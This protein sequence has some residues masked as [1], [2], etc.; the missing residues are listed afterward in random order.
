MPLSSK[1]RHAHRDVR[2]NGYR[3]V[4]VHGLGAYPE[5]TWTSGPSS[6]TDSEDA[7]RDRV[8]LLRDLFK[9]DFPN[10]RIMAFAHNSDWLIDAPVKSAQQIGDRLLKELGKHRSKHQVRTAK[11]EENTANRGNNLNL[12]QALCNPKDAARD[13]VDSTCGIVFLGTPHQGSPVSRL[14]TVVARVTGFFGSNTGLLLSLTS[15]RE[16]LS[17]LDVRF[18][19]CMKEKEG[20]RQKTEIVAFCE[21]KPTRV[22]GWLSVGLVGAAVLATTTPTLN[23]NQKFVV[24]KLRTVEGAAFNSHA[25]EHVATCL[26]N[27]RHELLD[28]I[29]Q[30]ADGLMTPEHIY[31]LQGK[32]GTGKSTIARTVARDLAARDRLAASF[33]FK[34]GES[35]RGTAR[36]FFTTIAA[37][38]VQSLPAVAKYVRNAI[39]TDPNIAERALGD[40]F[41]KLILEPV[42][43]PHSVSR[44]M[45]VVIDALDECEGDQDVTAVIKLLLQKDRPVVAPLK[46]FVTSRF[47]PPIRL[48]FQESQ[49][50]FIEFPIHE[51]P[52]PIIERDIATFLRFRF[53]E[54]RRQFGIASSWPD[55]TQFENLLRKSI[56]LFIFAATACRFVEDYRQGGGGPDDRLQKI[57]QYEARG[58]FDQTYLPALT[59]MIHG[60][61]GSARRNSVSEF[62]Q[63]VGSIVTLTNPLAPAPLASLLG[64]SAE[65]VNNRLQ[66]LHSVLDVPSDTTSP[67]RIFHESFRDFL[68]RPDP[69]DVHEFWVDEK[70]THEMLAD[71][72]FRLLSEGGYLKKDICGLGAPGKPRTIVDQQTIDRCLPPEARYACLYW[73]HHLKGSGVTLHDEHQALQFL[74]SHFLHWLE[75]LSLMGR[76]SESI[77]LI[78]ELQDLI[79]GYH[80]SAVSDFLHDAKR[81]ILKNRQI[82]DDTPLQL[83]FSG[84]IFAPRTAIIR[85]EFQTELLT[86]ACQLPQ[87]EES[88]SAELQTL[89][90]HSRWV[91]S[92]A[93]SPD[94]RMLASS[95]NDNTV[96]LWDATTGALQ[97]ILEGHSSSVN[98]VY[99]SP[100]GRMI[101]SISDDKIV[102]H[103]DATTGALQQTLEGHSDLVD[104][105]AFSPDGRMVAS[106]SFDQ[107]VRLWDATTGALQQTLE[108]HSAGVWH[109]GG[110][111][112]K[113]DSQTALG[114]GVRKGQ[115]PQSGL[116][117]ARSPELS[118][119][120]SPDGRMLASSF[121]DNIVRLWDATTGA[122]QQALEGHSS[123][124]TSVA[125][126]CDGRMLASGSDD[127]TVRLWHATTGALQQTLEGHS[128]SVVSVTFSSD[129]RMLASGSFDQTVRLWDTATGA[130]RQILEGHSS[131]V[132]SVSFSPDGRMLASGSFDQTVRLWDATTGDSQQILEG[133]SDSVCSVSFSPDGRMLAS[134]SNDKTVR[135]W[136]ATT[137]ALRQTLEGHSD[138]VELQQSLEGHSDSVCSV[139]FSPD[140]RMLA[141]G[142]SDH[143]VRLWDATT[144]ALQQILE[145]HSNSVISVSFSPDGR[146][147][148][149]GSSDHTVRLWDATT[150]AL[151][152]TLEGHS[153]WVTSV[154]FSPDGR[155]LASG[156][157][158]Q[159][160]RLWDA[161]TG[162]L[163]QILEGHSNSVISVSF[164]PDGRMLASG[165][166]DHTVRLWDATTGA[167]Q[168]TLEGHSSWVTSVAFSPDGRMLASGSFD[169]T[170]RLW[171]TATGA[172]RQTLSVGGLAIVFEFASDG[173][174]LW[175]NLGSLEISTKCDTGTP[176]VNVDI[177]IDQDQWITM[178]GDRILWLPPGFR[179]RCSAIH[180]SVLA[181][182]HASGRVSFIGFRV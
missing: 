154:A 120:F 64:T 23:G 53:D 73:V 160:V 165:S 57:L 8:H 44:T 51:I 40:Q 38:L 119:S 82:A 70:A 35:D 156:S 48:G 151:Q 128:H 101:A 110:Q 181:I 93:F 137:G 142:S 127:N 107:T 109:A 158:D 71:R 103:W 125:F 96:R 7:D 3:I 105:V 106:G 79:D 9:D 115:I 45:T 148:A 138:S 5:Y 15:H 145:G 124:V 153:S 77:R 117:V 123:W 89:E 91:T 174:Y 116:H 169:Q 100:D 135:L 175:T 159:T 25:N 16:R 62:K 95:S 59:Q 164:S 176:H 30:W 22:L 163:Q 167:L 26:E 18:V 84:L 88:W 12:L 132:N 50:K 130:L 179:P 27:T 114:Q 180:G 108:G 104:L 131:S 63:I 111:C 39:E 99:F 178:K 92:V 126:S 29:N 74:Q 173:S 152:Q 147:L 72:C 90:G 166:S 141:S 52:Q 97:Q 65:C 49:G 133:H 34:R 140:G 60:I 98:S 112:G 66:L 144:G 4:A 143:T 68:I 67:V 6:P 118:V 69:E 28:E 47:E 76:I 134:G 81:F 136:D 113:H 121:D 31:W 129:S 87:V 162:A 13:V 168:Q 146:M 161:T 172:L 83:Y 33:F 10:A 85:R 75:A 177:F 150:G 32:A 20:R 171:D 157:L 36:L 21:T 42:E 139:S 170:V 182:G 11:S 37:Q 86:W 55:V 78:N 1:S 58:N 102:R 17:D 2:A 149:S 46:F 14:G 56:P 61:K 80:R 19:E 41:R 122:L 43:A 155:M 54:I 24:G 94:G